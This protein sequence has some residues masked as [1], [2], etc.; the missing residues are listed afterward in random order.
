MFTQGESSDTRPAEL[1]WEK[2]QA[3]GGERVGGQAGRGTARM[4]EGAA[5][6]PHQSEMNQSSHLVWE[7]GIPLGHCCCDIMDGPLFLWTS[8]SPCVKQQ[9]R[10]LGRSLEPFDSVQQLAGGGGVNSRL[11]AS[12][13]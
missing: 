12:A 11:R 6:G 1:S 9:K 10:W 4:R 2:K 13:Q 3:M 7:A 5:W 8:V